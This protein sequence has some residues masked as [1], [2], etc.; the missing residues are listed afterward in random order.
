MK[1]SQHT[2]TLTHTS[3]RKRIRE[4]ND[5]QRI[6]RGLRTHTHTRTS[7][8]RSISQAAKHPPIESTS[9]IPPI[10]LKGYGD[11]SLLPPLCLSHKHPE[12]HIGRT[13]N[14]K[15]IPPGN[16]HTTFKWPVYGKPRICRTTTRPRGC[17]MR[18]S[19]RSV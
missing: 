12:Q 5:T 14:L 7:L 11:T 15:P 1:R 4:E 16:P 2:H 13:S 17:F 19:A 6:L 9:P 18:F 3:K 10:E 8:Q